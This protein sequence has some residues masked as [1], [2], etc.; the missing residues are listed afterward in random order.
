MLTALFLLLQAAP[1]PT[2]FV[3]VTVIA[4]D[5]SAPLAH[6]T[7]LVRDGRI[8][9]IGPAASTRLAR[10]VRRIEGGGY[11][12]P[13]FADMHVHLGRDIDLLTYLANGITTVRNLWGRPETLRWRDRVADGSLLGPTIVTSGA[14]ID[15]TPPS[16]PQMTVITDPSAARAEVERQHRAGYDF[17]KVYNSV[18]AGVYDT[19]T[20]VARGLGMPV[21]G[22]VPFE[23]GLRGALRAGQR[24]IEHLRGYIADLVPSDAAVQPGA[25]LKSRSLAWNYIDRSRIPGLVAASVA[26]GVW[27]CPTLTVT[28][29]LLAPPDEW[30]RL[31]ARPEL[32]YLGSAARFDR[33]RLPYLQDFAPEDYREANRGV[34]AQAAL[35]KALHDV[36]GRLLAGT[37][38]YLQGF[39]LARE[40]EAFEAAGIPREAVLRI[41]TRDAAEY[42]GRLDQ[43]GTVTVGKRAD[44]QLL[45]GN[46]LESLAAL[47]GRVGVMAGGRW[48]ARQDL[49]DRLEEA[50]RSR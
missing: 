42:L 48:L 27:N 19:I 35:V 38:S 11:L 17:I 32:R 8:A 13:G 30:E 16:V 47:E 20:A 15:G 5:G 41:A 6:Q 37:D 7:V 43:V 21:A 14:I 50:A 23:V 45:R 39:A 33:S 24:S 1:P 29:E 22:H 28:A 49:L 36:G 2:A 44:L 46:P 3:D 31:G 26:A 18:P 4:L 9:S 10:D 34:A 12:L 25:S 40:L